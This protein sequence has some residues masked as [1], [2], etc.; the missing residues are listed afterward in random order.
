[1]RIHTGE[2]PY[3]CIHCDKT[4]AEIGSL[5]CHITIHTGGKPYQCREFDK[6]FIQYNH[7]ITHLAHSGQNTYQ[8]NQSIM[9]FILI[10][11]LLNNLKTCI[12]EKVYQCNHCNKT[13]SWYI[14]I[15]DLKIKN[16]EKK[17][18]IKTSTSMEI[19]QVR[20]TH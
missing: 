9:G 1:M 3:Q 10:C 6:T 12:R 16:G 15:S 4:F 2:K 19:Y 7:Y 20:N 14:F 5:T 17:I 13:F 8:C 11:H 18:H